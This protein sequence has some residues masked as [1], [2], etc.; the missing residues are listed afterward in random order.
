MA[1]SKGQNIVLNCVGNKD[2]ETDFNETV[3]TLIQHLGLGD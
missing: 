2:G 3:L 1:L